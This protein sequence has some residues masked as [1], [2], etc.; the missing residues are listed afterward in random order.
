MTASANAPNASNSGTQV[1]TPANQEK[2]VDNSARG[3]AQRII[4]NA[5]KK[6]ATLDNVQELVELVE[7]AT[8]ARPVDI[9]DMFA[10]HMA[11]NVPWDRNTTFNFNK[12][13]NL[14]N[15]RDVTSHGVT[16]T[17]SH[18]FSAVSMDAIPFIRNAELR[19]AAEAIANNV[20]MDSISYM[21]NADINHS[22]DVVDGV[23]KG[24]D[25][26]FEGHPYPQSK[27]R[28]LQARA[29]AFLKYVATANWSRF[30]MSYG[31][32]SANQVGDY[33]GDYLAVALTGHL[34]MTEAF[35]AARKM[36]NL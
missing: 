26:V 16:L 29:A 36:M 25:K 17:V 31:Y 10:S 27:S 22:A 9:A 5:S 32:G 14:L 28:L 21:E 6:N 19:R 8:R 30:S 11:A 23:I 7:E 35:R 24:L 13:E 4:L 3:R 12:L 15:W 2:P 1:A 33:L 34:T 20:D 18:T